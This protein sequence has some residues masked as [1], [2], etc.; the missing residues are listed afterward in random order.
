M[1]ING[2]FMAF[3][4]WSGEDFYMPMPTMAI[5]ALVLSSMKVPWL[6]QT[7]FWQ[8]RCLCCLLL[9]FF[10][11][12]MC[13]SDAYVWVPMYWPEEIS[14]V[15]FYCSSPIPLRQSLTEPE[16]LFFS[17]VG[18]QRSLANLF[19]CLPSPSSAVIDTCGHACFHVNSRAANSGPQSAQHR[20]I[21]LA[22]LWNLH[23]LKKAWA[24]KNKNVTQTL[25]TSKN[26]MVEI[27]P[28][29]ETR[30]W[31]DGSGGKLL[32]TYAWGLQF[33]CLAPT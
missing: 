19:L 6:L 29:K 9:L 7:F 15:P 10:C 30:G 17:Q 20:A 18:S 23:L 33:R 5:L 16:I 21:S 11:M 8:S 28:K 25:V 31:E 12:Y 3:L 14:S 4:T 2:P 27:S 24:L 13:C 22:R 32:V 26:R 1:C